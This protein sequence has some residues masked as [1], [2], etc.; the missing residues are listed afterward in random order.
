M[1]YSVSFDLFTNYSKVFTFQSII[2]VLS[3]CKLCTVLMLILTPDSG[4]INNWKMSS[5]KHF[6]S[7][8]NVSG[9]VN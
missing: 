8:F 7:T 5:E 1:V 2:H 4:Y 3:I 6:A 9:T